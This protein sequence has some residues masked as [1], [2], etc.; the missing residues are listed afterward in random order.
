MGLQW[1]LLRVQILLQNAAAFLLQ[2]AGKFYHKMRQ[3]F[4]LQY[5]YML[6]YD[7]ADIR[8]W[9][10]YYKKGHNNH[11]M[12][13]WIASVSQHWSWNSPFIYDL[14]FVIFTL[15]FHETLLFCV[16]EVQQ[17]HQ[18]TSFSPTTITLLWKLQ[19]VLNSQSTCLNFFH[20][21]SS[22]LFRKKMFCEW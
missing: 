5:S 6:L 18:S 10:N 11:S 20:N 4:L 17:Q 9:I 7:A 19:Q 13:A 8:K 2:S 14:V 21:D 22:V 3:V 16:L 12:H 15:R 1:S